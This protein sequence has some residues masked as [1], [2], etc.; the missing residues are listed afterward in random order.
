MKKSR[1]FDQTNQPH[2]HE[3]EGHYAPAKNRAFPKRLYWMRED[4][5]ALSFSWTLTLLATFAATQ[6][7]QPARWLLVGPAPLAIGF[8]AAALLRRRFNLR[9]YL[10]DL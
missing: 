10:R 9:G 8:A 1:S 3:P 2:P 5:G 4:M 6:S 7:D